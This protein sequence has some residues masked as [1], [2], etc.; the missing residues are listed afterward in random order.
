MMKFDVRCGIA[1]ILALLPLSALRA[2]SLVVNPGDVLTAG[3]QAEITYSNPALA[4]QKVTVEVSGGFPVPSTQQ[5]TIQLDADGNGVG[6][7]T[8]TSDWRSARFNAPSV[9]EVTIPIK[10]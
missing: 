9:Q 2:Q 5:V 7:W 3:S 1:A 10:R 8:V 4:G 6:S